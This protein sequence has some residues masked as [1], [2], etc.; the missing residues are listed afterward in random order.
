MP[1]NHSCPDCENWPIE[2]K[3][4]CCECFG[5]GTNP[6]LNAVEPVCRFCQG[7]GLCPTCR[8]TGRKERTGPDLHGGAQRWRYLEI[9]TFAFFMAIA[10][11]NSRV[12]PWPFGALCCG[13]GVYCTVKGLIRK[14]NGRQEGSYQRS[15]CG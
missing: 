7:D 12:W 15:R 2:A 1:G 11:L 6:H 10:I 4:Q 8:G 3:G 9:A 13:A 5:S 14:S